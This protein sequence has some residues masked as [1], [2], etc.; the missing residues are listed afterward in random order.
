MP[1][2]PGFVTVD[3]LP[4]FGQTIVRVTVGADGGAVVRRAVSG[5]ETLDVKVAGRRVTIDV[6][7]VDWKRRSVQLRVQ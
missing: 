1:E 7:A 6:L 3:F 4:E 2:I 5:P